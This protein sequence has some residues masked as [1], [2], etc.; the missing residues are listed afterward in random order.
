MMNFFLSIFHSG[1]KI[2]LQ[3]FSILFHSILFPRTIRMESV[4]GPLG[5]IFYC[6]SGLFS[7]HTYIHRSLDY[8]D[9]KHVRQSITMTNEIDIYQ[10]IG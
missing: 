8:M 3:F 5:L 9:G 10:N 7:A 1:Q 6:Y 4:N 2:R